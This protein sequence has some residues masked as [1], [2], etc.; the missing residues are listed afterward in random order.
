[1]SIASFGVPAH[2][3]ADPNKGVADNANPSR[4]HYPSAE[5]RAAIITRNEEVI[6]SQFVKA[7]THVA[8]RY[9]PLLLESLREQAADRLWT[10]HI[11]VLTLNPFIKR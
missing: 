4:G 3:G 2:P 9:S 7:F 11:A 6:Q 1:M 5:M 10:R 8:G